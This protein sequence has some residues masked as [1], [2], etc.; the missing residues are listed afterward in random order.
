MW[1]RLANL[2][3]YP[4]AIDTKTTLLL[5]FWGSAGQADFD[6]ELAALTSAIMQYGDSFVKLMAGISVG[7]ED[8]DRNSPIGIENNA[9]IGANPADIVSYIR[10]VRSAITGFRNSC[11]WRTRWP[12]DTWTARVNASNE[13]VINA[14]DFVGMDTYPH[15][16]LPKRIPSISVIKSSSTRMTTQLRQLD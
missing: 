7:S 2:Y 8:L 10:Q 12:C 6:N 15:L 5:G 11:Q 3:S 1:L 14:C 13:A 9:G 16:Q 4:A